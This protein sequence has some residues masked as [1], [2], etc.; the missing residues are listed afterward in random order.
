MVEGSP[1]IEPAQGRQAGGQ[2]AGGE[3]PVDKPSIDKAGRILAA[4]IMSGNVASGH[5]R[6]YANGQVEIVFR[7]RNGA[8]YQR[9]PSKAD[10]AAEWMVANRV[11]ARRDFFAGCPF[12]GNSA[13]LHA[14]ALRQLA[15]ARRIEKDHGIWVW[16]DREQ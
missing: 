15:S 8:V 4:E 13:D 11:L 6:R 1:K 9:Q 16:R 7:L 2:V 5:V 10:R 12:A 3:C 14:R